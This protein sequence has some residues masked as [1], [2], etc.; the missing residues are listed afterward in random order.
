MKY[1]DK[2]KKTILMIVC[3]IFYIGY[4]KQIEI[5]L[6]IG[7]K[8]QEFYLFAME[9]IN[10]NPLGAW[11]ISSGII[12][13]TIQKV[14]VSL[15]TSNKFKQFLIDGAKQT[16]LREQEYI[17]DLIEKLKNAK[18]LG[19]KDLVEKYTKRLEVRGYE[20]TE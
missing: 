10:K 3:A 5:C 19:R 12:S 9:T 6:E 4:I 2:Y 8:I 14:V 20:I 7:A 13:I 18:L 11:V 15:L 17:E 1:L 16:E